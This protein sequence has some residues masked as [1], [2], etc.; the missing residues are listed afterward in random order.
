MPPKAADDG[1]AFERVGVHDARRR[2]LL[3]MGVAVDAAGQ[4]QFAARVDL[5][6]ARRQVPADGSDG[7]AGDADIGLEYVADTVATRPPRITRS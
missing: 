6:L 2:Q 7:L 5:A 4:H 3:D 1:R